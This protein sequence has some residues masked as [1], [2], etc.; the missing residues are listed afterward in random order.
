MRRKP[1]NAQTDRLTNARLFCLG[2]CVF[3]VRCRRTRAAALR[4]LTC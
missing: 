1:R 2:Y 4:L 3:G